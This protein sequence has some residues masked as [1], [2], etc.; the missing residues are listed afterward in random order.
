MAKFW[1]SDETFNRR[2]FPQFSEGGKVAPTTY[3]PSPIPAGGLEMP[4][5][6]TFSCQSVLSITKMKKFMTESYNYETEANY[7]EEEPE[8]VIVSLSVG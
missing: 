7:V 6:P 4:A 2:N 5:L 8:E 3:R 1:A